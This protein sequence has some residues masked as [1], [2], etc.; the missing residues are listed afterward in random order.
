VRD[1]FFEAGRRLDHLVQVV[2]RAR[3]AGIRFT[4]K[5]LFQHQTV[6]GWLRWPVKARAWCK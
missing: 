2:S 5:Q 3:Q 1:N 4:P 6:Q